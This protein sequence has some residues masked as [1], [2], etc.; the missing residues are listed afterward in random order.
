[1]KWKHDSHL[2]ST[3]T[4]SSRFFGATFYFLESTNFE[5]YY[6]FL[7]S[8]VLGKYFYFLQSTKLIYFWQYCQWSTNRKWGTGSRMVT[9]PMT[10]CDLERSR[11]WPNYL[12]GPISPKMLEIEVRLQWSSNRKWGMGSRM[13]SDRWRHVTLKGQD[14]DPIIFRDQYLLKGRN[15]R[16]GS[17]H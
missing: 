9:W 6:Y 13:V 8:T 16:F 1:M 5:N 7:E 4:Y 12:F 11:S 10:S 14:H 2:L 3:Y 17:K 15:Q